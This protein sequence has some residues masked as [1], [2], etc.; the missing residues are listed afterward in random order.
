[1]SGS[2][3][4]QLLEEAWVSVMQAS[5]SNPHLQWVLNT[6]QWSDADDMWVRHS[7]AHFAASLPA[8]LHARKWE[9]ATSN[10][11]CFSVPAIGIDVCAKLVNVTLHTNTVTFLL[12][13][14]APLT[15][16]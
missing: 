13:P 6:K 3:E 10:T 2:I 4:G 14:L 11:F 16:R 12:A 9:W 8:A 1:M 7:N 5:R 15:P